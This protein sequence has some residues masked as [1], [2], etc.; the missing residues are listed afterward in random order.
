[1]TDLQ[2]GL[3]LIGACAVGAVLIYNRVQERRAERRAEQAFGSKHADLL[4]PGE[5]QRREPT[6]EPAARRAERAPRAEA[7]PDPRLDYVIALA[8]PRPLAAAAVLEM[9][10]PLER[11][12][13]RRA[14]LAASDG[15]SW[16]RLAAGD[17]GSARALHAG[18]QL[19]SRAGVV[20]ESELIAF[21][22]EIETLAAKLGASV[23]APEMRPALEAARELDQFCSDADIQVALHVVAPETDA[24][25][26]RVR[27][28]LVEAGLEPA[29]DG[30]YALRDAE[31]EVLFEAA[32]GDGH[33][34]TLT[35]DVARVPE[36]GRTYEAMVR[37]ARQLGAALGGSLVDDNGNALDERALVAIAGQLE[38][39]RR[40]YHERGFE[41]G[42]ALAMRLF[43]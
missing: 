18:L 9:W 38:A 25:A 21:R 2:L 30:R 3:L 8:A 19:V 12:F 5:S 10:S 1:M 27:D 15:A 39:V 23:S 13:A 29:A 36:P 7:L 17:P 20:G 42:S 40:K 24:A 11:R 41:P 34:L 43:S 22:S 33:S 26:G 35:L 4:A 16:R 37:C 31:G 28:A 6:L 32:P 14:V